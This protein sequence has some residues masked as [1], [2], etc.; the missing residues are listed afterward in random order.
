MPAY[1][2]RAMDRH[3]KSRSFRE[4]APDA[5]HAKES[6]RAKAL[7][8]TEVKLVEARKAN[9]RLTIPVGQFV[10]LLHQL[11]LQVRAGV[12]VDVALRQLAEDAPK[13]AVKT[14]L[15]RIQSEVAQGVPVHAACRYFEKQFPPHVAAVIEAGEMS[16]QLPESL[17]ALAKHLSNAA[18]LRRTA[19]RALIYPAIVMVATVGLVAFLL[20]GVVPKFAEIFESMNLMLPPL[21][22]G[23]ITVSEAVRDHWKWLVGA[24]AAGAIGERLSR[25]SRALREPR[26]RVL[27]ALPLFG[28]TGVLLATA[29][30][31]SNCRLL[32]EAGVSLL[33]A[34]ETGSQLANHAVLE[35]QLLA[36]RAQVA[37]GKPL[38]A[39]LPRKHAFPGFLVPALRAGETTGQLGAALG[40]IEEYAA[41]RARERIAT[42]MALLEPALLAF[43]TAVVGA[44]AL[45]FFLPLFSLLGGVGR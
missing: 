32:H 15:D 44:I 27:L 11:E 28:E 34:L 1:V 33:D 30:F 31:A 38:H 18:E 37:A 6:V 17:R 12:T 10:P 25:R 5:E 8:P 20:G 23:L 29:R 4:V 24:A 21:T 3:G 14:M 9:P 16:A 43:L 19:R 39:A 22:R 36:A 35:R 7:W 41:Q 42:A 45:S 26:A 2:V 13:G 40:H